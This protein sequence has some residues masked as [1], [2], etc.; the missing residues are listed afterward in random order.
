MIARAREY[1]DDVAERLGGLSLVEALSA[2]HLDDAVRTFGAVALSTIELPPLSSSSLVAAQIRV[3]A[4]LYWCYELEQAGLVPFIEALAEGFVRGDVIAPLGGSIQDLAGFWRH[5]EFHFRRAERAALFHRIFDDGDAPVT[6]AGL[7]GALRAF[8][9]T[10][11][12]IGRAGATENTQHLEVRAGI[13]GRELGLLA[14]S[15]GSGIAAFA[16]RDIVGQ[17]RLAWQVLHNQDLVLA[18]GG[19]TPWQMIERHARRFLGREISWMMPVQRAQAGL[20]VFRWVADE[21][22]QLES[23]SVRIARGAYVVHAALAW[24]AA[25]ES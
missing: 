19:G 16:A 4:A 3:C 10:L 20:A 17:V 7:V 25:T 8:V 11:E 14:T 2:S 15:R 22:A 1:R 18:L 21:A 6:G 23:A 5:R 12:A 13:Q 9:A 24:S